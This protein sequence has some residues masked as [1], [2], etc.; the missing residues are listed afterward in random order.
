MPPTRACDVPPIR[1]LRELDEVM[2][3]GP[4]DRPLTDAQCRLLWPEEAALQRA[5]R[6]GERVRRA[7]E[8]L[9]KSLR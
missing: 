4:R 9:R 2:P 1:S 3:L 7:R 6:I 5:R 8:N